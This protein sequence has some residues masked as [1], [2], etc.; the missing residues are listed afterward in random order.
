MTGPAGSARLIEVHYDAGRH[1]D[2]SA[3]RP[4]R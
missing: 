3:A 2:G 1:Y 4:D